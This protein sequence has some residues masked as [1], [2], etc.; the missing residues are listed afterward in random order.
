M[1]KIG[2]AFVF[3]VL[4][5]AFVYALRSG[6]C[7]LRI[8]S[9]APS[10]LDSSVAINTRPLAI[11]G[12]KT[13]P[14]LEE[15]L[16][17]L[18]NRRDREA[19]AIFERILLQRSDSLDAL[20]GKA[21]VLR[22]TRNYTLAEE[23]LQRIIHQDPNHLSCLISLAYIRYKDNNY[24]EAIRLIHHILNQPGVDNQT[25]SLAYIMQGTINSSR[26][27]GGLLNKLAFGT[28]IKGFFLKAKNLSPDLPEVRLGLGTFYLLAPRIAGG[29]L[30]KAMEELQAS[31]RLAPTFATALARLAQA[32]KRKGDLSR[33]T[34][35]LKNAKELDP[36]NEVVHQ[37]RGSL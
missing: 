34:A 32:Y 30:E 21:E 13:T 31:V 2:I 6:Q 22:R 24:K 7:P 4:F 36:E 17:L 16:T 23:L 33:F 11:Q 15:G 8:L 12:Q 20:W 35:Y 27:K 37:L 1:K 28:Q 25:R 3:V 5:S 10:S 29:D 18:K 14:L 9:H 26:A 19:L